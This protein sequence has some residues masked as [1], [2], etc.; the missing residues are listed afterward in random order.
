MKYM[1]GPFSGYV[2]KLPT[3]DLS[4]AYEI[5]NYVLKN[6]PLDSGKR[7]LTRLSACCELAIKSGVIAQNPFAGMAAEIKLPKSANAEGLNDIDPFF[8]CRK[9]CNYSRN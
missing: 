4:Q 9:G 8:D 6:I 7:F 1:Y 2:A 3:H 5:R